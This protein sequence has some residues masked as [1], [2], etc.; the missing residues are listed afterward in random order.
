MKNIHYHRLDLSETVSLCTKYIV[1]FMEF[2]KKKKKKHGLGVDYKSLK[3]C[4][5]LQANNTII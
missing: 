2:K 3:S 5:Y 4:Q 1:A